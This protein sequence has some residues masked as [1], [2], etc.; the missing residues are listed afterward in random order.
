[1][2][3][4]K[5]PYDYIL[6][7]LYPLRPE[8]KKTFGCYGLILNHKIVML[9]REKESQPEF[10]GV[11]VATRPEYYDA[12]GKELHSSNMKFDIDGNHHTWLFISEDLHDFDEL[13]RKAAELVK[14]GDERIGKELPPKRKPKKL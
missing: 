1:M 12:L 5:L 4:Y 13:I 3:N 14:G 10:N 9:L 8:I 2:M 11:F 6:S 7:Y